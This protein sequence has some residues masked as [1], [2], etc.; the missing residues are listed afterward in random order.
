M[1]KL[2]QLRVDLA[3][4]YSVPM[5]N[6][7]PTI[8]G[9]EAACVKNGE[10]SLYGDF[11]HPNE[12]G[13]LL[14]ATLLA[15]KLKWAHTAA[16]EASKNASFALPSRDSPSH[17]ALPTPLFPESLHFYRPNCFSMLSPPIKRLHVINVKGF[18]VTERPQNGAPDKYKRCWEGRNAGD[19]I[20]IW[21]PPS[22]SIMLMYVRWFSLCE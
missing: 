20:D 15:G 7:L 21:V 6:S 12:L 17:V 22:T 3:T 10:R 18:H 11:V 2:V 19:T 1:S 14:I 5:L 9:P 8:H 4:L 13:H 16:L